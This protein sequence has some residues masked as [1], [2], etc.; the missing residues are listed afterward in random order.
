[1]DPLTVGAVL[2]AI[3]T[4]AG[5]AAGSRLW[6]GVVALVRRP[7][8][9]KKAPGGEEVVSGAAELAALQQAPAG[10]DQ[11]VALARVLLARAATDGEFDRDLQRWW[12]Q[13][14]PMRAS[15]GD[16]T[17]TI[18][19]GNQYGPVLQGRDF[20]GITFG[21]TSPPPAAPQPDTPA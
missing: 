7:L 6:A 1:M 3:V 20:T 19:G 12:Q 9:G 17:N 2:L 18:S 8:H 4:G 10:Q 14:E 15:L 16:V 13:A 11:A 5:E 21:A